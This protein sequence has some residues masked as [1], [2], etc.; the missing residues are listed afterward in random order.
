MSG[1]GNRGLPGSTPPAVLGD[2]LRGAGG[3]AD[4][5]PDALRV[6]QRPQVAVHLRQRLQ[7]RKKHRSYS[8]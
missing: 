4:R 3:V 6:R 5:L 8:R 7:P 1:R 2:A